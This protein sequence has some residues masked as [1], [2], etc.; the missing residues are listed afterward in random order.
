MFSYSWKTKILSSFE[1][2]TWYLAGRQTETDDLEE[3]HT[4]ATMKQGDKL[5]GLLPLHRFREDDKN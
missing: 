1:A 5:A 4:S 3:L 2:L